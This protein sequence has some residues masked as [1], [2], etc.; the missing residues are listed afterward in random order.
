VGATAAIVGGILVYWPPDD[1]RVPSLHKEVPTMLKPALFLSALVASAM[2]LLSCLD[3]ADASPLAQRPMI[4]LTGNSSDLAET[5]KFGCWFAQGQLVCMKKK[6]DHEMD[7][8]NA[9]AIKDTQNCFRGCDKEREACE[10]G[11]SDAKR[12]SCSEVRTACQQDCD[13]EAK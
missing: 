7:P 3:Q 11:A 12:N 13:R 8:G 6:H 2:V 9:Q 4:D 10:V 1:G 5:I